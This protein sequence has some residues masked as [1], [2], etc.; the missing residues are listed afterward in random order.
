MAGSVSTKTPGMGVSEGT[1]NGV[2]G[3]G[4]MGMVMIPV[5]RLGAAVVVAAAELTADEVTLADDTTDVA[6]ADDSTEVLAGADDTDADDN[7]A[8]PETAADEDAEKTVEIA[9][10]ALAVAADETLRERAV[11]GS[12]SES[13]ELAASA[14]DAAWGTAATRAA[15]W[16]SACAALRPVVSF[17]FMVGTRKLLE[18]RNLGDTHASYRRPARAQKQVAQ[19]ASITP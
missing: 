17:S 1:G 8:D 19:A 15:S 10:D 2:K 7:D 14:L 11:L 4:E 6:A 18:R 9:E 5:S 13:D 16:R 3:T 12:A